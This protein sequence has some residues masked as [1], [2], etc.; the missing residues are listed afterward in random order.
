MIMKNG[1]VTISEKIAGTIKTI[2][3]SPKPFSLPEGSII[4]SN[5]TRRGEKTIMATLTSTSIELNVKI[6]FI[7]LIFLLLKSKIK[8]ED[9]VHQANQIL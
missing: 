1:T 2:I 6:F 4:A 3:I 7:F 8:I 9:G 5:C